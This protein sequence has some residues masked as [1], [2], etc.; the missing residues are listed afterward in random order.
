LCFKLLSQVVNSRCTG[1][2]LSED[3]GGEKMMKSIH[4]MILAV[5]LILTL[6]IVYDFSL[7]LV[8]KLNIEFH[9]LYPHFQNREAYTDFW[10]AYWGL[11]SILVVT[12]TV[13]LWLEF[14]NHKR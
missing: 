13:L 5:C 14:R 3:V 4:E 1:M 6:M 2:S 10:T 7:H 8:E 9:P 12:V 11:G